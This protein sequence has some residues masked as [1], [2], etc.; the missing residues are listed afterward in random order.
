MLAISLMAVSAGILLAL[1][2]LHLVYTF[3]GPKLTPRDPALRTAMTQVSPVITRDMT[4]WDAWVSFN[5]THS[6]GAML[7]GLMYGYLAIAHAELLFSSPFLLVLGFATVGGYAAIGHVY[8]FRAPYLGACVS[9][10][11]YVAGIIAA[12]A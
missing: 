8:W 4:M 5:A 11:C 2:T 12:R 1:G 10:A 7:Y 3:W 9:L 6:M